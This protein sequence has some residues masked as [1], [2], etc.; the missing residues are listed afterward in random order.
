MNPPFVK[1]FDFRGVYN[2]DINDLDAYLLAK[3]IYKTL[4][5]KKVLLGW[6]TRISSKNLALHF[7]GGLKDT[8][9][10]IHVMDKCPIDYVTAGACSLDYDFS[11]MFT[12]SHNP[13][14]WT[15]LLMHITG[16]ESIPQEL[17][18]K[19]IENYNNLDKSVDVVPEV[20]T[21][22]YKNVTYDIEQ[23]II[24]KLKSLVPI[25][26]IKPL[27]V[28]VDLGDGSGSKSLSLIE[29]LLPNVSFQKLYNRDV[30]DDKS[31]H[32]ADPSEIA[33]A[34]DLIQKVKQEQLDAG[35]IFDS[36]ADRVLA[37]DEKG[38]Y[39]NGSFLGSVHIE[40]FLKLGISIK[41]IG[42]A[43]DCGIS[44]INTVL[45]LKNT[46]NGL[47]SQAIP[48]GR[49]LVRGELRQKLDLGVENVGHFYTRDF[50]LTDSAVF[51]LLIILYWVSKNG[52][53]SQVNTFFPD[54]NR[55][56]VFLEVLS[57]NEIDALT[58]KINENFETLLAKKITVDGVRY[59][60]FQN[61]KLVTWYT[62]RHSGYE[63]IT[64][65]YFGSLDET[66][67]SILKETF[68]NEKKN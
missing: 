18:T 2:K 59:E 17:V 46:K 21:A 25:S 13:W 43:V 1:K 7:I 68:N 45:K 15:G 12:G 30:Y 19:I 36:D 47:N 8:E 42:Y 57:E 53:L 61:D 54:G 51:S 5:L 4:P 27:K 3:A 33:N 65:C 37:I 62:I 64:K 56:Q 32:V 31:P 16:G 29:S 20:N 58:Q 55:D 24:E 28:C 41:N 50:F 35:F 34:Q 52:P 44:I 11:I 66:D 49:S 26:Q 22:D 40:S 39:L 10:E 63:K 48:V 67:F 14:T 23:I 9:I 60:F 6:D 38:N